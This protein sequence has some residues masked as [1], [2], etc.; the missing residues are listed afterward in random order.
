[1]K[2]ASGWS[3]LLYTAHEEAIIMIEGRR[4]TTME[5]ERREKINE[6]YE[7]GIDA[8]HIEAPRKRGALIAFSPRRT[9][10]TEPW[11]LVG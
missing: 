6:R 3:L 2:L 10:G 4:I 11:E 7:G 9:C 5:S 1:M 8:E